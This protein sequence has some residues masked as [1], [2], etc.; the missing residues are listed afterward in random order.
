MIGSQEV[1]NIQVPTFD[2]CAGSGRNPTLSPL[3]DTSQAT[4]IFDAACGGR[5]RARFSQAEEDLLVKLK[6]QSDPKLS[7]QVHYSTHLKG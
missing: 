6:S 3:D 4:P 5:R 2:L 7:V 1:I